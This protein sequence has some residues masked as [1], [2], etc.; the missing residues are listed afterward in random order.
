[1]QSNS[2]ELSEIKV[3]FREILKREDVLDVIL[4]GSAFKGK[5]LP[6]DIDVAIISDNRDFEVEG[7]HVSIVSPKDFFGKVPTIVTTLI[8]EGFS[9]R[10]NKPLS[11]CWRF[12][13]GVLFSYQLS[14]LSN[15]SKVKIV[16]ALRGKNGKG[17]I[18]EYGGEWVSTGV[19]I[20]PVSCEH[21]FDG[22][23]RNFSIKYKKR[24][25]LMH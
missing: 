3:K 25:V 10:E 20:V 5:A 8:R 2:K 22:F 11:E 23:F 4:F 13:S 14:G 19:F 24:F 6:G 7:V 9:L 17:V 12:S 1:M 15:S 16:N 21:I 18:D